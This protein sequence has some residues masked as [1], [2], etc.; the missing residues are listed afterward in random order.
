MKVDST[1]R[2][3][4]IYGLTAGENVTSD[5]KPVLYGVEEEQI[6][7]MTNEIDVPDVVERAYQSALNSRLSVGIA[8]DGN[9]F[10]VHY[11]NLKPDKPLFDEVIT[12]YQQ[13]R[14]L[15]ANAARLV[16]GIPFK[17]IKYQ[18]TQTR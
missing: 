10:V 7:L 18:G 15:G 6:P 5:I 12:D 13:L 11:K 9:R 17:G 16:K 14:D 8:N 1:D 2:P 3:A 4:I